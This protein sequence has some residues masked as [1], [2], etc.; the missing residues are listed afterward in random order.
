MPTVAQVERQ[1]E[2][3]IDAV[4]SEINSLYGGTED[5]R[6][7]AVLRGHIKAA[8]SFSLLKLASMRRN[9]KERYEIRWR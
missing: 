3:F 6:R 9:V 4:A 8:M 5:D 7:L 1:L 2:R